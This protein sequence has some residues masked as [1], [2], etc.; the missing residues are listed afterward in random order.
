M[1]EKSESG[2]EKNISSKDKRNR[3][4]MGRTTKES[5]RRISQ[6]KYFKPSDSST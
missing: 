3:M 4:M 6:H 1:D 2:L 5:T